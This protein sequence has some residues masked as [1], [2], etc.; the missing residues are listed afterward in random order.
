MRYLRLSRLFVFSLFFAVAFTGAA[1]AQKTKAGYLMSYKNMVKQAFTEA[2]AA[3]EAG[4]DAPAAA[5]VSSSPVSATDTEA[6]AGLTFEAAV[7][8]WHCVHA[9]LGGDCHR[10]LL[11]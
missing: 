9:E 10:R 2:A 11:P 7:A 6:E 4:A 8:G 5:E 1:V 3:E